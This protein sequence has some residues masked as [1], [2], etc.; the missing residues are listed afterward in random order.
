MGMNHEPLFEDKDERELIA[1]SMVW[2]IWYA[3]KYPL[4]HWLYHYLEET[5]NA[6]NT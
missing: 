6:T 2:L 4:A 5:I 1:Q 3:T